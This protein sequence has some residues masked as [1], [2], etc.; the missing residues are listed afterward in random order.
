MRS[1]TL[2]ADDSSASEDL[3]ALHDQV[4]RYGPMPPQ[5]TLPAAR[6]DDRRAADIPDGD[7]AAADHGQPQL[8]VEDL[9][10]AFDPLLAERRQAP[11]IGTS[12]AN[13]TRTQGQRLEDIGAATE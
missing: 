12:D 4:L 6:V 11:D 8:V 7:R 2:P 5:I 13:G 1:R 3:G 9:E 10:H